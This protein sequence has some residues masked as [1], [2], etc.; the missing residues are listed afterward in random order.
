MCSAI[1]ERRRLSYIYQRQMASWTGAGTKAPLL[2][3]LKGPFR[4]L[5]GLLRISI[6]IPVNILSGKTGHYSGYPGGQY[7]SDV[8]TDKMLG[9]IAQNRADR[10]PFFAYLAY[11]APHWPLQAPPSLQNNI[12]AFTILGMI[13]SGSLVSGLYSKKVL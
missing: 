7:S 10:Q 5:M 3:A 13:V 1:A 8:Y 2:M 4:C 11:T 6:P 9:F 12:A